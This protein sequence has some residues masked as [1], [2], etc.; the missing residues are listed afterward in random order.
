MSR[1][2]LAPVICFFVCLGAVAV[3]AARDSTPPKTILKAGGAVQEGERGGFCWGA[4]GGQVGCTGVVGY[5]WPRAEE[6]EAGRRGR[7][8]IKRND[9]PDRLEL[10]YWREVGDNGQPRGEGT[11]LPFRL[12]RRERARGDVWDVKFRLPS[13]RG[14]FYLDMTG[15]WRDD[16]DGGEASYWFH[17]RLT[18]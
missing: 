8:R 2:I 13:E 6:A 11:E 1:L 7:I 3:A 14:H 4:D 15:R 10:Q 17:L 16:D 18:T 12:V 5:D 9:K